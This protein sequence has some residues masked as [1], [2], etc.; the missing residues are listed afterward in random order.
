MFLLKCT[1]HHDVAVVRNTLFLVRPHGHTVSCPVSFALSQRDS[2]GDN[3]SLCAVIG[4][5]KGFY[6]KC[7][8]H[9]IPRVFFFFFFSLE[10]DSFKSYTGE[11]FSVTF[12]DFIRTFFGRLC[13]EDLFYT[14]ITPRGEN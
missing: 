12:H 9:V 8:A 11:F 13:C 2:T 7:D 3:A 6:N 4:Y 5:S 10:A 14:I 1:T